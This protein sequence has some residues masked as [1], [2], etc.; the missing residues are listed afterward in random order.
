MR[1]KV[2]PDAPAPAPG[3]SDY[4][5]LARKWRPRTFDALIG[6]DH[7]ARP[8]KN[9]LTSGRLPQAFLFSGIRGVGKTTLA[10]LLAS[11][12]DCARGPTPEPCGQ[13]DHCRQIASGSHPDV[14]EI[15]AASH[16]GVEAMRGVLDVVSYMPASARFKVYVLDEVH[17]LSTSAF[18]AML[19]TLEEPPAHVKFIFATTE[20]GKVLPTILSRCQRY[21]L[22]RV[23]RDLLEA[24]LRHVLDQERVIH[25]AEGLALVARAADGSVRDALSLVDQMIVSGGGQV[26]GQTVRRQLGLSDRS[27]L[28]D[29][30]I[31]VMNADA[32]GVLT[33]LTR[34]H[35]QGSYPETVVAELL[36]LVHALVQDRVLGA[37]AADSERQRLFQAGTAVTA[38][39]LHMLYQGLLAGLPG[40]QQAPDRMAAL[41]MLLLRLLHLRPV[42]SIERLLAALES[43]GAAGVA[44]AA[45]KK[46]P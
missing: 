11:C 38:E 45:E 44:P 15:D 35:E 32:P 27:A 17:M 19:K 4:L 29:L 30:L 36:E 6:Q 14:M 1:E 2:P 8:L 16:T 28:I 13:C 33:Q 10:R 42:P 24:H 3:R 22:R 43:R 23:P 12:L 9:A 41:E 20:V 25:D 26:L 21:T 37:P 18:N 5:V 31:T 34:L 46:N 40:V 7:V 39:S